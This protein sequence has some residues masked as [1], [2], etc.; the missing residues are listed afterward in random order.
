[1]SNHPD[2]QALEQ[3]AAD[4]LRDLLADGADL[5][6]RQRMAIP[7]QDMPVQAAEVRAC[8]TSEVA[9]GYGEAQARLEAARCLRCRNA[10]CIAGC[11]VA[12]RIPDFVTAIAEGDFA[13][14]IG[15]LKEA[16]LL[17]AIC[18]RVCPQESQCQATCTLGRSLK[19][20]LKSVAIGRLE[21]FAA[22]WER[23][24]GQVSSPAVKPPTGRRVAVVGSGPAGLV[25]ATDVRREGHEVTVFEA[26][27][28]FGGVMLYGIPEFR[29]PKD[30][31]HQQVDGLKEMGVEFIPNFV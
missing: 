25:V 22:D 23:E 21:R 18:G 9:L 14:A 29:L 31:V 10:P 4:M 19:D 11:P 12:I 28:R 24:S 3:T 27:H 26:F 7:P 30:I 17:P 13:D 8:N 5:K 15:V 6:P 2:P 1:M 20:P 16:S